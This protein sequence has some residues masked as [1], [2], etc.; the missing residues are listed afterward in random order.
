MIL[1]T[2]LE[3]ATSG[4]MSNSQLLQ[5]VIAL[6]LKVAPSKFER[7]KWISLAKKSAA[8][9]LQRQKVQGYDVF[10]RGI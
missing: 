3:R 5:V 8:D 1:T 6:K 9:A 2:L 7:A 10:S 4:L